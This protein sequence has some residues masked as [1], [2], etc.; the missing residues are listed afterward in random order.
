G[1]ADFHVRGGLVGGSVYDGPDLP[2]A[3]S[4]TLR[5][6]YALVTA[7]NDTVS[8]GALDLPLRSDWRYGI[9]IIPD[10]LDPARQCFG[11]LGSRAFALA[12]PY[13]VAAS[14]SVYIVWGGN[15][16]KDPVVH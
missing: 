14:D 4:G 10:S 5:V 11:C 16:I 9:E 2:T 3:R 8:A 6:A 7:D 15:S 12:E 1:S 13:R